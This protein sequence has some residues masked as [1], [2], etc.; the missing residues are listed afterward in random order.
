MADL[1]V[2]HLLDL[3]SDSPVERPMDRRTEE[4]SNASPQTSSGPVSWKFVLP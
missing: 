3:L 1:G 4:H 2:A